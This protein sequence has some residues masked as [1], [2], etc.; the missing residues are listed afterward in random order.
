[1][2]LLEYQAKKLFRQIGIPVLPSETI[3]NFFFN[4]NEELLPISLLTLSGNGNIS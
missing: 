2:D 3:G 4:S 1:M